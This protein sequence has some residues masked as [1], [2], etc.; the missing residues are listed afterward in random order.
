MVVARGGVGM[1]VRM[2][3]EIEKD[4]VYGWNCW[5]WEWQEGDSL[6]GVWQYSAYCAIV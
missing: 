2:E 4:G 1:G 5:R 6:H 3:M